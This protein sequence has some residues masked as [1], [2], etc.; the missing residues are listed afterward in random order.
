MRY[1]LFWILSAVTNVACEEPTLVP[2]LPVSLSCEQAIERAI[3]RC[4]N[5]KGRYC[6]ERSIKAY[7]DCVTPIGREIGHL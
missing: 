3:T 4:K 2:L 1:F 6:R 7:E 5:T